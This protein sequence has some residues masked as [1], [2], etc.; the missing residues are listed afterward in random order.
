MLDTII[1]SGATVVSSAVTT[2]RFDSYGRVLRDKAGKV[3]G[4][5]EK[6]AATDEQMKIKEKNINLYAVE[7]KW[8][9]QNLKKIK[10]T[11]IK[12]ERD[13]NDI[14]HLAVT[15]GK[16]VEVFEIGDVDE[17]LGINTQEERD[18]AEKILL[19]RN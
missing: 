4:L 10:P 16:R 7:N 2:E 3:N 5:V 17:A 12:N 8:L 11:T 14:V 9:F 1:Q 15:Q 19:Q 6:W 13:I 18:E